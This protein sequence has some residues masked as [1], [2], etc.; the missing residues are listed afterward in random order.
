MRWSA[1]NFCYWEFAILERHSHTIL[2]D[3]EEKLYFTRAAKYRDLHDL[4]RLI[5]NQGA[6]PDEILSLA[7][8]SVDLGRGQAHIPKANRL[9]LAVLWI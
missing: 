1:M 2:T 6:R 5:L 9:P 4:G 3:E 8:T 7:K